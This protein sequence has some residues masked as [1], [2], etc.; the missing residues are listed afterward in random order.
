MG[1]GNRPNRAT[2]LTDNQV[3]ILY[4]KGLLGEGT[5]EAL[6]NTVWPNNCVHLALDEVKFI[7]IYCVRC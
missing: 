1:K 5:A 4:E 7:M 3:D 6:L 2:M